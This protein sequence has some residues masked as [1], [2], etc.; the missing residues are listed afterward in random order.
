MEGRAA[1]AQEYPDELCWA[2]CKGLVKHKLYDR[3]GRAC[4]SAMYIK[5]FRPLI[6][7]VPQWQEVKKELLDKQRTD[8]KR[9][10]SVLSPV[11]AH[12]P[13]GGLLGELIGGR[14]ISED[15][16]ADRVFAHSPGG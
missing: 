11:L 15:G 5:Q 10:G 12:L 3:I 9:T 4:A 14:M 1:K 6:T 8:L 13:V 16:S 7:N 2:I